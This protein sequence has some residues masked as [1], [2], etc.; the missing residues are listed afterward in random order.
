MLKLNPFFALLKPAGAMY[1]LLQHHLLYC[2]LFVA[3]LMPAKTVTKAPHPLHVSTVDINLNPKSQKLEVICSIFTDDFESA[4]AKQYGGKTD[5]SLPTMHT[6]MEEPVKKYIAA[7]LQIK[8]N[9]RLAPMTYLGFEKVKEIVN[10]YYESSDNISALKNIDVDVS[11]LYNLYN[12]QSN[13]VHITVNGKRQ[14]TKI[15]YPERKVS[16]QY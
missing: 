12:D 13:I 15:D 6:A 7:H 11:L 5:L 4:L 9:G 1:S 8:T 16:L 14:S 10:V 2:Y 3:C